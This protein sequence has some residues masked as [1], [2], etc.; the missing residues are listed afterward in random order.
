MA[1]A[2]YKQR[3]VFKTKPAATPGTQ[4]PI[5]VGEGTFACRLPS[6]AKFPVGGRTNALPGPIC[7]YAVFDVRNK[8]LNKK[9]IESISAGFKENNLF[10]VQ[11]NL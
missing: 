5:P 11:Q 3:P 7:E 1:F 8:M 10:C 2:I 9:R 6:I 4:S